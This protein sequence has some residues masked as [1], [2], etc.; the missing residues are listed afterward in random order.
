MNSPRFPRA[1]RR[2]TVDVSDRADAYAMGNIDRRT[3]NKAI[4]ASA[5][6]SVL[7]PFVGAAAFGQNTQTPMQPEAFLL[8]THDSVRPTLGYPSRTR[9]TRR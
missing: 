3:V 5:L 1:A 8:S 4:A 9:R 2:D 6:N 7:S